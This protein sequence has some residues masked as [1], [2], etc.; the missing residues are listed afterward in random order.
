MAK[1]SGLHQLRG[2]VGEHS[3]YR[4]TGISSGLV[5]SINQGMSSRVKNDEAFV[6]TRLNNAEFGQA[7]RIA[8]VLGQYISPKFRPMILP[9]SQSKMAKV[10]LEYIKTDTTHP[11]GERNIVSNNSVESQAAALNSVAKNR[12]EDFG[13]NLVFDEEN[14]TLEVTCTEET[15]SKL[16]AIG[17]DG[18]K[19]RFLA[20]S[21]WIGNYVQVSGK[22]FPTIRA[23]MTYDSDMVTP[24]SGDSEN[25]TYALHPAPP[26]TWP[27]L[28]AGRMGILIVMPYRTINNVEHTLQEYCTFKAFEIADGQVN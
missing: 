28:V 12:F 11:W 27:V 6:N 8:S 20:S 14:T 19:L 10:I 9:F 1:Q 22:Y 7:G 26:Q 23:A 25:F 21:T 3:Y 24:Q 18:L 13:L 2:K 16:A 17:A 15:I 5:R 4:Q